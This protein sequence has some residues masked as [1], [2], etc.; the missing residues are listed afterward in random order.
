MPLRKVTADCDRSYERIDLA[1]LARHDVA[2]VA[3]RKQEGHSLIPPDARRATP[4]PGERLASRPQSCTGD[5][6]PCGN[7]RPQSGHSRPPS[8]QRHSQVRPCSGR[9]S[10]R[11]RPS[12]GRCSGSG[13]RPLA[14]GAASE[15][16]LL[17]PQ[18]APHAGAEQRRQWKQR[19]WLES[20]GRHRYV[21]FSDAERSELRRYFNAWTAGE[22]TISLEALKHMLL[23]LNLA[24][25]PEEIDS[26]T[27]DAQSGELS[28]EGFLAMVELRLDQ[29]TIQVLK[30]L[31]S[32]EAGDQTLDYKTIVEAHRR[33]FIFDAT[34]A[35]Q[36][37]GM[38][39]KESE[40]VM[41]NFRTLMEAQSR[42]N[43]RR[44][45][46][47]RD[48][49]AP[50]PLGGMGTMWQVVCEKNGLKPTQPAEDRATHALEEPLSPRSVIQRIVGTAA[51]KPIGPR[52]S[53]HTLILDA[54]VVTA[55]SSPKASQAS[56]ANKL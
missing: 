26:A 43:S 30:Q 18:S 13:P 4:L 28:F 11:Q 3:S 16:S 17:R 39:Q 38:V 8:G 12:S 27:A 20:R 35:R 32:G 7:S 5:R 31:L 41:K 14:R 36:G 42:K 55:G 15:P 25:K 21:N 33:Q 6:P 52:R 48:L 24:K 19:H 53:G 50:V 29:G 23:S 45:G 22:D 34:G 40:R 10:S 54:P 46:A 37:T 44:R 56:P 49:D 47:L 9:G 51:P 2:V 1:S